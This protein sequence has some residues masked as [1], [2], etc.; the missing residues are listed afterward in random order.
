MSHYSA[1][2]VRA[3]WLSAVLTCKASTKQAPCRYLLHTQMRGWWV[4]EWMPGWADGWMETWQM[5]RWINKQGNKLTKNEDGPL[6]KA[7]TTT[8]PVPHHAMR[9][10][11]QEEPV[12]MGLEVSITNEVLSEMDLK[13]WRGAGQRRSSSQVDGHEHKEKKK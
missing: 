6:I 11:R 13:K 5:Q 3:R 7:S 1:S 10:Q 4:G 2:S 8:Q 12:W 9:I